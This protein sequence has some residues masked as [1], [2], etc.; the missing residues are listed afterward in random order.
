MSP[1]KGPLIKLGMYTIAASFEAE[2]ERAAKNETPY[3]AFLARL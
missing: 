3:A 1:L 2:A